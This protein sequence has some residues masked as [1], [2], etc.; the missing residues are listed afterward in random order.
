MDTSKSL[1]VVLS[2]ELQMLGMIFVEFLHHVINVS[3]FTCSG[4]HGFG[5][6]VSV[7]SRSVPVWEEFWLKRDREA[8]FFSASIK[9]ISGDPHVITALNS[10]SWTNLIFPLSWH[11]L[12][13]GS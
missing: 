1:M 11:D 9:E 6:E 3:H 13:V 10:S 2:I 7:A 12:S 5:G 8:E 4:S